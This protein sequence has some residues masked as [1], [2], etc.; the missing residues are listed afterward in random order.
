[1]SD[2]S[3][4]DVEEVGIDGYVE[5]EFDLP[6]ALLGRI[7]EAFGDVS[8]ARLDQSNTLAISDEQGVYQLFLDNRLVYIGKTDGDAGLKSRLSRHA[9]KLL[10]RHGLD[11]MHVSFKAIRVFVFTA[12]DLEGDLIRHYGGVKAVDWNGSGFGSNDPG[13]ERD[14]SK[15]KSDHFDAKFLID[16]DRPLDIEV[17][18]GEPAAA[19]LQRLKS[20][21]PSALRY[22]NAGGNW[23]QAHP[24]LDRTTLTHLM[25]PLT[26]RSV[27]QH[28]ASYLP[29]G[30]HI[31]ALPGYVIMYK[32]DKRT[33][34]SGA[35]VALSP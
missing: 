21:V 9:K 3:N 34:P 12:V 23:R 24:D 30:W 4:T 1:M 8:P 33:F 27:L 14:T 16:L 17:K 20:I 35:V 32:D 26:A 6:R 19:T 11:P 10:H 15:V 29:H 28:I 18:E 2:D 13:K 7:I 25:G 5:F 31:T 22:Q